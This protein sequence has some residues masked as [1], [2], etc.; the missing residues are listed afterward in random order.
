MGED[1]R[2]NLLRK[3][4]LALTFSDDEGGVS[5][6]LDTDESMYTSP[7]LNF[8]TS[9]ITRIDVIRMWNN[10][11]SPGLS[12]PEGSLQSHDDFF[13]KR[14]RATIPIFTVPDL[15]FKFCEKSLPSIEPLSGYQ[16][17]VRKSNHR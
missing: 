8:R 17:A 3:T 1:V 7:H 2:E 4:G 11:E 15:R 9:L 5:I 14:P 13:K 6:I 16:D 10:F 12:W